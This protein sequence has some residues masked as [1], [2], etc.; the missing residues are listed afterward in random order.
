MFQNLTYPFKVAMNDF[1][2]VK[3]HDTGRD[4]G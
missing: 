4:L 2:V 1:E 3:V